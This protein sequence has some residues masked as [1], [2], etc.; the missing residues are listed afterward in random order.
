MA[1][2]PYYLKG[3]KG[4]EIFRTRA[5]SGRGAH[6]ECRGLTPV[7]Y[8]HNT[9]ITCCIPYTQ[10]RHIRAAEKIVY[11]LRIYEGINFKNR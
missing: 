6:E 8:K 10:L 11:H 5:E 9:T 3:V 1:V 4:V 2:R 7:N